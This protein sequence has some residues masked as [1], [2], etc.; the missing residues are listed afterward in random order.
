MRA[1]RCA[2]DAAAESDA[3]TG[4]IDRMSSEE[5]RDLPRAAGRSY[6]RIATEE[7]WATQEMID[8]YLKLLETRSCTDPGF[9]SLWGHYASGRSERAVTVL[10]R[11]L[12]VGERRLGDMDVAG[13]DKQLLLL[14]SPGVQ[15]FDAAT[16]VAVAAN[17]NDQVSEIVRNKPDRFAALAAI[18]PQD[19]QAAAKELER[20]VNRLKLKGAVINSHTLGEL[21]ADRKFWPI[22]EA[23]AALNVPV[24]L[25]PNTPP[26]DMIG[27]L[28][29]YGLDGAIYGFAVECGMHVLALITSGVFDRFPELRLV[30]GHL[31]EG[32]PFWMF[33]LDFMHRAQVTAKRY[34]CLQP[35]QRKVSDYLR[36]NIYFTTSGMAWE[37]A[38]MFTR[39]V[40][41]ADRVLY[42]M[43]YP[44]QYVPEEVVAMER[45]PL[46]VPE[47]AAFFQHNAEA[48]FK[49]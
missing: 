13:I 11:L 46:T 3:R 17:S 23:A 34:K 39:S 1:L 33:R 20:S 16:A 42:A 22:F 18:A 32:L 38:V 45:L 10:E 19:P 41:G 49:L 5:S 28:L 2:D 35:L 6:Q 7:A 30:V 40:V 47:K 12:D 27:P 14:T 8:L 36:E 44:Y 29:Q 37:P 26:K 9:I 43:D 21:L 15:V 4:G 25:H 24:Y 31:G 48:V